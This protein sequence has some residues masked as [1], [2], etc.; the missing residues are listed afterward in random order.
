MLFLALLITY[1]LVFHQTQRFQVVDE[2][3]ISNQLK[4]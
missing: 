4:T 3:D 2:E 1:S